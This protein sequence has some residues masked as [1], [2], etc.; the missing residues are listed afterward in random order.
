VGAHCR[1][2][3]SATRRGDRV[4]LQLPLAPDCG[5]TPVGTST[6][7]LDRRRPSRLEGPWGVEWIVHRF[8][9]NEAVRTTEAWH[10]AFRRAADVVPAPWLRI[11]LRN[12]QGVYYGYFGANSL[13]SSDARV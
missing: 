5:R 10:W 11:R 8:G 2:E 13:A 4:A 1:V 7:R 6:R 3:R 9:L 12:G